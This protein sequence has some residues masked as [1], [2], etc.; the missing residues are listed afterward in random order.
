MCW[1]TATKKPPSRPLRTDLKDFYPAAHQVQR[2]A[3]VY[4][5]ASVHRALVVK[6]A[7]LAGGLVEGERVRELPRELRRVG[8]AD[9]VS[10][11]KRH[12]R[13][14]NQRTQLVRAEPLADVDVISTRRFGNPSS[15]ILQR[16]GVRV[17]RR[18][19]RAHRRARL[20][21]A[22]TRSPPVARRVTD[23]DHAGSEGLEGFKTRANSPERPVI[24]KWRTGCMA[25]REDQDVWT[26]DFELP[27]RPVVPEA[28]S[29]G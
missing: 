21:Q 27:N 25:T 26:D 4:Q 6:Y 17:K 16:G 29:G 23:E 19:A 22:I 13:S 28:A 10:P 5:V 15:R 12:G 14:D 11:C 20:Q 18:S 2:V 1:S 7:S 8:L 9:V 3:S 24:G